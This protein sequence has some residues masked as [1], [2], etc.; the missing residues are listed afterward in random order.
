MPLYAYRC[1]ECQDF[2]IQASMGQVPESAQCPGCGTPSRRRFTAPHLSRSSTSA[3]RLIEDSARS[4]SEPAVVSSPGGRRHPSNA[5]GTT[6]NPLH[7]KL[8]RPD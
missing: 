7:Q 3:Y 1:P 5:G 8:P 4:A 6:L 2:E